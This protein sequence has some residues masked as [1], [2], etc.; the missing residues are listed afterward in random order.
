MELIPS[1]CYSVRIY[2]NLFFVAII[3]WHQSHERP[4]LQLKWSRPNGKIVIT[5]T[6]MKELV[7][8][9]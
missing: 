8:I 9:K 6:D 4:P 2:G 3:I 1:L 5:K 7:G